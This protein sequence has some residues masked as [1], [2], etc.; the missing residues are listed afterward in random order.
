[1]YQRWEQL[2]FLHW[3]MDAATIQ[4][5]LP[6]GLLVDT[7]ETKAW[8]GL[9]PLFM[10]N[11]RPRFVPAVPLISDFLELNLRTYVHDA[12][13]RPG[14]YFYS[15]D[16][17]QPLAVETARRL[18]LLR[19]EHAAMRAE[20]DA[21]GWVTFE[22]TRTGS[23]EKAEFRYNPTTM[24][25]AKEAEPGSLEFFLLERYRLFVT[26]ATGER[27]AS[28]R[29]CHPPYR[30]RPAP[31]TAWHDAPLRQA[32]FDLGGRSPEHVCSVEPQEVEVFAPESA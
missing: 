19:Y 31:V 24:G 7:H 18:L 17:D 23:P 28:M 11:V 13:G 5:T 32:G 9:V 4:A 2:L 26:D 25:A 3:T 29:V 27:R 21:Q 1:M 6:P 15:L 30:F 22:A 14:L 8:L 20:V 16:C 12:Q 10:R